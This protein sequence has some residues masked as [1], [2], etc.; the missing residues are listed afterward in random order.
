LTSGY[1]L[2]IF[3]EYMRLISYP[4]HLEPL[5]KHLSMSLDRHRL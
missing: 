1:L 4:L 2:L 5:A 3:S